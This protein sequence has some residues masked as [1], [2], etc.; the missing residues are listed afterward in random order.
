MKDEDKLWEIL[1]PTIMDDKPIRTRF[2]RV[3]DKKVREVAGGL[4][5][6]RP[7]KGYWVNPK[8]ELFEERMIPV[9][10]KCSEKQIE[11]IADLTAQYYKQE[12]IMYTLVS[13]RCVIKH[14]GNK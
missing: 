12:A 10:I 1:V 14:Y 3:W 9:R 8:G 5:V 11:H 7:A 2:H 4:T 13:E 6:L